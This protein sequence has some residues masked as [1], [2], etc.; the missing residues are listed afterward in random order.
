M[1]HED[2]AAARAGGGIRMFT[3][4]SKTSPDLLAFG[5]DL[6]GASRRVSSVRGAQSAP[7]LRTASRRQ[8][9]A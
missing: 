7:S 1:S 6:V 3:F 4:K 5:G 2:N 9:V 8:A